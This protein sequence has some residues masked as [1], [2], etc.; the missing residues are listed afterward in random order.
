M[1]IHSLGTTCQAHPTAK[2][3]AK[4]RQLWTIC[5]RLQSTDPQPT[6]ASSASSFVLKTNLDMMLQI[7]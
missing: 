3:I 4:T 5:T 2:K 7:T 6:N 1:I